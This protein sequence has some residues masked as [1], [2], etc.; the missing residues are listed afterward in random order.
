M[1]RGLHWRLLRCF[2]PVGIVCKLSLLFTYVYIITGKYFTYLWNP[3]LGLGWASVGS[4][5][6]ARRYIQTCCMQSTYYPLSDYCMEVITAIVGPNNTGFIDKN[7][8]SYS[9]QGTTAIKL[10]EAFSLHFLAF[11]R[12]L[13]ARTVSSK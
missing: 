10:L 7:T 4:P 13:S 6:W 8:S 9:S 11:K 2:D 12:P 3:V 1:G 5:P